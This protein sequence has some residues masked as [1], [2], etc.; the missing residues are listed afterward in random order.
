M[1]IWCFYLKPWK[2]KSDLLIEFK[3]LFDNRFIE[4][5]NIKCPLYG[6]TNSKKIKNFF[7]KMRNNDILFCIKYELS[8]DEYREF[9]K[10]NNELEID[11]FSYQCKNEEGEVIYSFIPTTWFESNCY[12]DYYEYADD[13]L[14]DLEEEYQKS[15][16]PIIKSM[17]NKYQKNMGISD[18]IEINDMIRGI[19][20][21]EAIFVNVDGINY[22]IKHFGELFN[23]A[24]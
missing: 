11:L 7:K 2:V 9:K 23:E 18:I 5:D 16:I 17:K 14:M 10:V 3:D 12:E 1:K 20:N 19:K 6:W 22:L 24:I 13:I 8:E 21:G 15:I 4:L